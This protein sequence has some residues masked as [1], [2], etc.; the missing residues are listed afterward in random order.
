MLNQFS[1][2]ELLIGKEAMNELKETYYSHI[3]SETN[4][5]Y[6]LKFNEL[7][8]TTGTTNAKGASS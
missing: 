2:E 8:S 4:R 5:I 7:K 3:E 6:N 1:R